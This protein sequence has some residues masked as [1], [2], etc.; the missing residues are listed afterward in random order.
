MSG[1]TRRQRE[2][3]ALVIP[4]AAAHSRLDIDQLISA[5]GAGTTKQA[6]QCSLRILE[7]RG[8]LVRVYL[9]RRGRRR[10]VLEPTAVGLMS[11]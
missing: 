6:T 4:A 11:F 8:V 3:M 9:T 5:L 7:D 1:W 2:I 10:M